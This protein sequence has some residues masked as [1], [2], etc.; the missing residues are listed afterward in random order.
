MSK[1]GPSSELTVTRISFAEKDVARRIAT[2]SKML[3]ED[4]RP[5]VTVTYMVQDDL[6]KPISDPEITR[7]ARM[8]KERA[9]S[10]E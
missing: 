4:A 1:R 7:R 3:A 5:G 9:G 2:P 10:S 8:A 6:W